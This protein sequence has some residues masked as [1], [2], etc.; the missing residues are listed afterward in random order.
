MKFQ[1]KQLK[2]DTKIKLSFLI[3]LFICWS[4]FNMWH[5]FD[6]LSISIL[7]ILCFCMVVLVYPYIFH[8]FNIIRYRMWNKDIVDYRYIECGDN[9]LLF[10]Y[11][12]KHIRLDSNIKEIYITKKMVDYLFSFGTGKKFLIPTEKPEEWESK[13]DGDSKFSFMYLAKLVAKVQVAGLPVKLS[14]LW[15][16]KEVTEDFKKNDKNLISIYKESNVNF[17][18]LIIDSKGLS[19]EKETGGQIFIEKERI[20]NI[21]IIETPKTSYWLCAL[22]RKNRYISININNSWLVWKI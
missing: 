17:K 2:V 1:V 21:F 16:I 6:N 13:S 20:S 15:S 10:S 12:D 14:G 7:S 9:G 22:R 18:K 19:L 5:S 11:K 3:C 4:M 8:F